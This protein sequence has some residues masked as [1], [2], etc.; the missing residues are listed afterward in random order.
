MALIPA[1]LAR[2]SSG[3]LGTITLRPLMVTGNPNSTEA[4]C[5]VI[6]PDRAWYVAHHPAAARVTRDGNWVTPAILG[7]M[8]R[9]IAGLSTTPQQCVRASP[10]RACFPQINRFRWEARRAG[11]GS[12]PT[13]VITGAQGSTRL[14]APASVEQVVDA[15]RGAGG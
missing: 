13:C 3:D 5:A 12:S 4:A 15:I 8:A 2:L 11:V 1:R 10:S 14:A 7:A 6:A 9:T